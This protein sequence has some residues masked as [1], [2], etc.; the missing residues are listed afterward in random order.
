[1]MSVVQVSERTESRAIRVRGLVQGVGF[2]PT[3]WRLARD[4]GLAGYVCN[5]AEGVLI[6]A[7]GPPDALDRF[8]LRLRDESPPLAR[9]DAIESAVCDDAV[10][11]DVFRIIESRAGRVRTG[12]VA[13]AATCPAC[14]AETLDPADR[15]HGYAFTNCTHC[16]P[17]LS[18]VRSIPYD[19]A[20]TSMAAFP[21]CP[22]C[23][24]E[25]DHPADRRFHAQPNACAECGP[26]VALSRCR[27]G[28][29]PR[30]YESRPAAA[31]TEDPVGTA[32]T[33]IRA[34]A[35]VAVKGLGGFHLACD[36]TDDHAVTRLR[37][38]KRRYD[39]P[40]ALM[41]RNLDTMRQ[42][43]EVDA[44]A[45]AL[46]TSPAAPIVILPARGEP[47]ADGVAPNQRTLGFMLPY[48]PLHHLL[49]A[50]LER[51][52]VLT[53]GNISDEPQCT[54]NDEARERLDGIADY[55]LDHNR[56]IVNRV[57]DSVA[58]VM[59]GVLRLMR[60]AR[61][62][63]PAPLPLP[64]GFENAPPVLAF[65][66]E[67][68]NTFCLIK[69]G[70]AILSQHMGDLENAAAFAD[71][72]RNLEL[73][74]A[75]YE[76]HPAVLAVD[77]HPEYLSSKLGRE[78][79][80]R[81][82]LP[83]ETVQHHHAHIAA[84]MADNNIALGTGP[85]LGIALDGLGY[86]DNGTIWGG[87]FLLADY[88]GYERV[89]CFEPVPMIGGTR[90]IH[91]PW[92]NAYAHLRGLGWRQVAAHYKKL[93]IIRLL[94]R[95]P[96]ATLDAMIARNINAPLTSSCGR[97]FDAVAAAIGIHPGQVSYE[98]Q[99]AIEMEACVDEKA[100]KAAGYQFDV[101]RISPKGV[102]GPTDQINSAPMWRALLDDVANGV[103]APVIAARF[104]RGLADAIVTL[105][106]HLSA[107]NDV[108]TV[109]LSGGVFQ[110]R[111]VFESVA[112]GLRARGLDVLSHR[113]VPANDGGLALGQAAV[114]AARTL[115]G[116]SSSPQRRPGSRSK[117]SAAD[118][119]D[120]SGAGCRPSP[121]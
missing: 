39:K 97:L 43:V 46:L 28:R 101:G 109:A 113:Q 92:R 112:A 61:G 115:D 8:T 41:A 11:D 105:A 114:A 35:I 106:A 73:Y 66:G 84:C 90:A 1:M 53:S 116:V 31:P 49:M 42:Y 88:C 50:Q 102:I 118:S 33:L 67:L 68:K 60:R 80:A 70:Q 110:N 9:V 5:D 94:E 117:M 40:F 86:G 56:D 17:R 104:H 119:R 99:A 3:V 69:D 120:Q 51:P 16:G 38:R 63:A 98:G 57:D 37:A 44:E 23:Q 74:R 20:H 36:A 107:A 72:R 25:Y 29:R 54:G 45:E 24:A 121:A 30:I 10:P 82:A 14:A 2:R 26:R 18:I 15:R 64:T 34:G 100:L 89:A 52:I 13:D 65:G 111:L 59:D 58:R 62:F 79:A 21:M 85:V 108:D 22:D 87:E 4:G 75:L 76:H 6:H 71:Y 91:E 12:I 93:P 95:Q 48:T 78:R 77:R 96:L 83:L 103:P 47:L 55:V 81:E 27:S 19:R 32:A 7:S